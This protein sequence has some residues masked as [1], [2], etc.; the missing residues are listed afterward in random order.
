MKHISK[1]LIEKSQEAIILALETYNKPTIK[2]RVEGFCFF[3]TNAWELMLKANIIEQNKSENSIYYK[4]IKDQPRKSFSLRDC[5][6]RIFLDENHPIRKNIEIIAD[7]RDS[8]THLII[9][10]LE[11]V[12]SGLFQAGILNY[13]DMLHSWFNGC[14]TD[15]CS[16]ALMTLVGDAKEIDPIKIKKKYGQKTLDFVQSQMLCLDQQEKNIANSRFRIPIEY[17]LVLTKVEADADIKLTASPSAAQ[18]ALIVEVAKNPDKTH[19]NLAK[20]IIEKVRKRM[21]ITFT[22]FDLQGIVVVENIKG[23]GNYHFHMTDPEINKYSD[24]LVDYI[25]NKIENQDEY[26]KRIR[27]KYRQIKPAWRKKPSR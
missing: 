2:Y 6:K 12:Y 1:Q 5:V 13:V 16:P 19:P 3:F 17:K 20:H 26:L 25:C 9:E 18:T 23:N 22:S 4:K 7:I 11:S 15:K 14:I 27:Q 8:A 10:E 24:D 21:K